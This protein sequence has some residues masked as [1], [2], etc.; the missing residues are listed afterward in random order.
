MTKEELQ[1]LKDEY[2]TNLKQ[3]MVEAGGMF[4][5]LALFGNKKESG[6]RA[7]V[8]VVVDAK[9]TASEE[10]KENFLIKV[11]PGIASD[12][13]QDF[14]LDAVAWT[15][16]AWM[17]SSDKDFE[18]NWQALPIQKEVLII[19]YQEKEAGETMVFEIK[20]SGKMIN[21]KGDLI[22]NIN[23]EELP[24][25]TQAMTVDGKSRGRLHEMM[26]VFI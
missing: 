25:L 11:L 4:S 13:K 18:G 21:S 5:H 3:L 15:S 6:E 9:H 22:D 23:L 16:E 19:M 7:I 26:K 1:D 8:H 20:R 12:I 2:I 17:R 10:D 14:T 24:E